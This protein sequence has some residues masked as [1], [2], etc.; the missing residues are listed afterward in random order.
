MRPATFRIEPV[1]AQ[2]PLCLANARRPLS[3]AQVFYLSSGCETQAPAGAARHSSQACRARKRNR[4]CW[5][6]KG[7]PTVCG[8]TSNES[9]ALRPPPLRLYKTPV[10]VPSGTA[11]AARCKA[12]RRAL[13]KFSALTKL[14]RDLTMT[15]RRHPRRKAGAARHAKVPA[16]RRQRKELRAPSSSSHRPGWRWLARPYGSQILHLPPNSQVS[17]P[18]NYSAPRSLTARLGDSFYFA[19]CEIFESLLR[20]GA[21]DFSLHFATQTQQKPPWGR[22]LGFHLDCALAQ[23]LKSLFRRAGDRYRSALEDWLFLRKAPL[24]ATR[25]S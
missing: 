18:E 9:S 1:G 23:P 10:G 21:R 12:S 16:S 5:A 7:G 15:G 17:A 2:C 8:P 25:S 14:G 13:N 11:E 3:P 19:R 6:R 20:R 24:A 4:A 22:P